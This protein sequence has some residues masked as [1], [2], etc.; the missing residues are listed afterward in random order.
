MAQAHSTFRKDGIGATA[1]IQAQQVDS[2][3]EGHRR[4]LNR[5]RNRLFAEAT[6][7]FALLLLLWFL[8]SYFLRPEMP[9]YSLRVGAMLGL[10]VLLPGLLYAT[11]AFKEAK[12]ALTDLRAFSQLTR[13]DISRML[14]S[15]TAVCTEIHDSSPYIDVMHSQIGDSLAESEVEV[16]KVIEQIG[17]LN[18]KSN[19]QRAHIAQSIRSSRELTENT[20]LRGDSNKQTIEAIE[21][22]LTTQTDEFRK[23]F[24]RIRGLAEEIA[25]LNPFIQVITSIAQQTSLLALNAEIEA[26]HAG[27]AG[28]GFAVVANEVRQLA[29]SSTKAGADM[30]AKIRVTRRR[31]EEE[32]ELA[33]LS[34]Q[35]HEANN[36]M[37]KM[38]EDL[39]H[40]Q[41]EFARNS[42][43]LLDVISQVDTNYEES[44]NRLSE[45]LGHIQFQ[46]VMRQ[47]LEHVQEALMEMSDHLHQL[48]ESLDDKTWEGQLDST[49]KSILGAH[50]GRYKMASQTQTHLAIAGGSI[51]HDNSRPAIELF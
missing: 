39:C 25:E 27:E 17:I 6:V 30:A 4:R 29:V 43:L 41:S 44:V 10:F 37:Q 3:A 38:V 16:L 18:A 51:D 33:H 28:H 9:F 35:R 8:L 2:S 40:M 21:T 36:A 15:R 7:R 24:D 45:A 49:F 13:E 34:L 48:S 12:L 26:A 42:Q 1:A 50:L 14:A 31:V 19:E 22:H 23:N 11:L 32:M 46:D 47:R 20:R 5:T